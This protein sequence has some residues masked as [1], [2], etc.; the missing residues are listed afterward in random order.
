MTQTSSNNPL[1]GYFRQPKI[2]LTLPSA[3]KY[4]PDGALELTE[5]GEL[6]VYAM[7]ARDE[8]AFKTPDALLNGQA[9]VDVIQSCVPN[10]KNAWYM[11]SLDL[12]AVLIA[13][14]IATYGEMMDLSAKIP[15]ID[16]ERTYQ[17]DLRQ[18][19]DQLINNSFEQTITID[20][21][22]IHLKPLTY[23]E[24][25]Q[26]ALK[27]F[28]EQRVFQIVNNNNMDEEDKL[29]HFNRSFKK[30]TD[31]TVGMVANSISAIETQ[32]NVVENPEYLAEFIQNADQKFYTEI[33]KHIESQ[34]SKFSVKPLTIKPEP[35]EVEAGAPESFELPIVFDQANF[36]A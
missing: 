35:E 36:F 10:I 9:T 16:E 20:N 28:E 29:A 27:T 19:L 23:Q 32:D 2:Y 21:L 34:K 14:R 4:Y 30:L 22:V 12:D 1:S 33:T 3:G 24:F 31:L 13:I 18:V 8:I 6:P 17:V 5:T 11:P 15:N 7:T 25:T 26:S